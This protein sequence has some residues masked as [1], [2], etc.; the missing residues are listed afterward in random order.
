MDHE[1][2]S[3]LV[4][5]LAMLNVL[6]LVSD[7][8][9]DSFENESVFYC[10]QSMT[11]ESIKGILTLEKCNHFIVPLLPKYFKLQVKP[12]HVNQGLQLKVP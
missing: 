8:R 9:I 3:R 1:P 4:L 2:R 11:N 12:D 10:F 7:L 6:I 5:P